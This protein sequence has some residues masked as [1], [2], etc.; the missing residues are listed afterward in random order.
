MAKK[1]FINDYKIWEQATSIS[2]SK[3][4]HHIQQRLKSMESWEH[5]HMVHIYWLKKLTAIQ[6]HQPVVCGRLS[7]KLVNTRKTGVD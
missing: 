7:R 1:R 6:E 3:N 2:Q 4:Y 5:L